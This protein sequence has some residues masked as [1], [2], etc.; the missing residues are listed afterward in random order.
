MDAQG[1]PAETGGTAPCESCGKKCSTD[2]RVKIDGLQLCAAC[3]QD[4]VLDIKSGVKGGVRPMIC[5]PGTAELLARENR[6]HWWIGFS[7]LCAGILLMS[8]DPISRVVRAGLPG[9]FSWF[10]PFF[11]FLVFF[12][13]FAF[14]ASARGRSGSWAFLSMICVVGLVVLYFLPRHCYYC[15][16]V[17]A[18]YRKECD[19]CRA[20]L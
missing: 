12:V 4:A 8:L 13:G 11:G 20:P 18:F 16:A 6:K 2:Q 1:T 5:P 3:K 9:F 14:Y 17:H 15:D 7:C 19:R 10:L